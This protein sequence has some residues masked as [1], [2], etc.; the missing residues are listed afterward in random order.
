MGFVAHRR[1]PGHGAW[2]QATDRRDDGGTC[3]DPV[4]GPSM[5]ATVDTGIILMN[6]GVV[7]FD[8]IRIKDKDVSEYHATPLS[9]A[10][11]RQ[12]LS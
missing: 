2:R 5:M 10:F 7:F 4:A 12:P 11:Y 1:D 6:I 8:H 3:A 9:F